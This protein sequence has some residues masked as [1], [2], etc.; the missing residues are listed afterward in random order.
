MSSKLPVISGKQLVKM[1]HSLGYIAVRQRGSHITMRLET[2]IGTH[3]I[4]VPNH[5][6]IA[7]G[8]LDDILNKVGLWTQK[9]KE[10]L[11]DL[12]KR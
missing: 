7:K 5:E 1:M 4:T 2:K 6:E 8:T 12:L 10:S 9:S 11:I 3:S